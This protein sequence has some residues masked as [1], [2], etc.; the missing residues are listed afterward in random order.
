MISENRRYDPC[1]ANPLVF[2]S[3]SNR[4]G[5]FAE[6]FVSLLSVAFGLKRQQIRCTSVDGFGLAM[7]ADTER[8]LRREVVQ[9]DLFFAIVSSFSA[10]SAYVVFEMGARWGSNK[11]LFPVLVGGASSELL[12]SGPL[13]GRHALRCDNGAHV[14]QLVTDAARVLRRQPGPLKS[15]EDEARRLIVASQQGHGRAIRAL[16]AD[17]RA[18]QA[19]LVSGRIAASLLASSSPRLRDAHNLM[20]PLGNL[21]R[22]VIHPEVTW[23]DAMASLSVGDA[24]ER[25]GTTLLGR[26]EQ[27]TP[28]WLRIVLSEM[29]RTDEPRLIPVSVN[30]IPWRGSGAAFLSQGINY[31]DRCVE[32]IPFASY[33]LPEQEASAVRDLYQTWEAEHSFASIV[34]VAVPR[35]LEDRAS[36][37][38]L[39]LN[40]ALPYPFGHKDVLDPEEARQIEEVLEVHLLAL[41]RALQSH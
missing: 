28:G 24:D 3:H 34:A 8:Q 26:D 35:T 30:G 17:N 19:T 25:R 5:A 13:A 37:G 7:G 11:S 41:S 9:A 40:F 14:Q 15:Y 20:R 2:V 21:C 1:V 29:P 12:K 23:V 36:V 6:A 27:S 39:N 18:A 33:R 38:V 32:R 22:A 10:A 16:L 31:V 4:D